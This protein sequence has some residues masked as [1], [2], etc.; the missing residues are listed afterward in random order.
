MLYFSVQTLSP[1]QRLKRG[2]RGRAGDDGKKEPARRAPLP[3]LHA[4]NPMERSLCGGERSKPKNCAKVKKT[5]Y[6][7]MY[8]LG[9][10]FEWFHLADWGF[11][12]LVIFSFGCGRI[13]LKWRIR[14]ERTLS[15]F[16]RPSRDA[17]EDQIDSL[18]NLLQEALK[19]GSQDSLP[20]NDG[21]ESSSQGSFIDHGLSEGNEGPAGLL[22]TFRS[23]VTS[24]SG[25]ESMSSDAPT[26]PLEGTLFISQFTFWHL[27]EPPHFIR[28]SGL[29]ATN[30]YQVNHEGTIEQRLCHMGGRCTL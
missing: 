11:L 28:H 17:I 30:T 9:A 14:N 3:N 4:I 10:P 27:V 16:L 26:P 29:W 22:P 20:G 18:T 19:T 12:V 5:S 8:A 6:I 2:E 7:G 15:S 23:R 25:T 1:P 21:S 24:D 13:K